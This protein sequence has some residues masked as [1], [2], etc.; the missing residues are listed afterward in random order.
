MAH[1]VPLQSWSAG[2]AVPA[3][4]RNKAA[5]VGANQWLDDLP[6][7]I[8]GLERDWSIVVGRPYGD[9][10]EAFVAEAVLADGTPAV[11]KL[12]VPRRARQRDHSVAPDRWRRLRPGVALRRAPGGVAIGKARPV[13]VRTGPATAPTAR[14]PG[15]TATRVWR[16][17]AD[18]GLPTGAQKG[19]WLANFV[20]AM[21]EQLGRPCSERAVEY[22]IACAERRVQAHD[23]ERAVLVHG[24]VHAWNT[25]ES[26]SGSSWWIPMG[27]SPKPSTTWES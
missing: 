4:V 21:W 2:I 16:P 3:V 10:T 13:A 17:A 8:A 22:A 15:W 26:D 1:D 20:T 27:C 19:R 7:L 24:D 18:C 25:L 14:D 23:G 12:L 5:A 9:A 11:V 6:A